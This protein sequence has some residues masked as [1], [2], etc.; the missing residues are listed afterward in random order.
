MLTTMF[1]RSPP[2]KSYFFTPKE[3]PA[4]EDDVPSEETDDEGHT[5]LSR[6]STAEPRPLL[7]PRDTAEDASEISPLL[8]PRSRENGA[9]G[10]G[11][12]Q[13]NGHGFDLESQ[14]H[15][16]RRKWFGRTADSFW[17]TEERV[18]RILPIIGNPKRW[19]RHALWE[20]VVVAPVACLPAVVVGLLLNILDALSYGQYSRGLDGLSGS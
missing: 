1:R 11:V 9:G 17:D 19:N 12:G 13:E 6:V 10:Y 14:K 16:S 3:G 15:S 8:A 5:T 4:Y 7:A 18:A 2:D 20:N